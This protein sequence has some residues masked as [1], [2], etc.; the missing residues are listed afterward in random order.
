MTESIGDIRE[1]TGV[2]GREEICPHDH[3]PCGVP[4]CAVCP[5]LPVIDRFEEAVAR[6]ERL[7]TTFP[8]FSY[9]QIIRGLTVPAV[10][11]CE[12]EV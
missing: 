7:E 12:G 3:R 10:A 1:R 11:E 4:R 5:L 9:E 6:R 2:W 8:G